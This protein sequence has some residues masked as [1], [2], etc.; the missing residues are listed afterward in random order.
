MPT[1]ATS[2]YH[3]LIDRAKIRDRKIQSA[4][5]G[6]RF[7]FVDASAHRVLD[8]A[9]LLEN[10]FEHVMRELALVAVFSG[11]FDLTD[12]HFGRTGAEALHVETFRRERNQVVI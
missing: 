10:L 12:L 2:G 6:R 9:R 5:F 3:D 8:G 7:F 4:K 1:R 11:E